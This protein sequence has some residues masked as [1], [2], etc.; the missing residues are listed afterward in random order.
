MGKLQGYHLVLLVLAYLATM[1]RDG[2]KIDEQISGKVPSILD[3]VPYIEY[4]I[5]GASLFLGSSEH[6]LLIWT[7]ASGYKG[8]Q[9][10]TSNTR[11]QGSHLAPAMIVAALLVSIYDGTIPRSSIV[12]GYAGVVA[13]LLLLV[14]AKKTDARHV[15]EDVVMAHLLFYFTK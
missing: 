8:L 6:A 12:M 7:L 9:A 15:I 13:V 2:L 10:L 14:S 3:K 1:E 5:I 4:A 11:L